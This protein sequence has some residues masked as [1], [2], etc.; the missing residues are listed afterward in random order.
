MTRRAR[1]ALPAGDATDAGEA[2]ANAIEQAGAEPD[3]TIDVRAQ[4]V[5]RE[6][7]LRI[8]D[9]GHWRSAAARSER[10]HGLRLM[11]VLMDAID[12]ATM[13]DGTRVEL[14]LRFV[15][16]GCWVGRDGG[17]RCRRGGLG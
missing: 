6:V 2:C 10:G 8:C 15:G 1:S 11:R 3:S 4:L 7:V 5:G 12:I 16:A 9:H 17:R 13:R 14:R